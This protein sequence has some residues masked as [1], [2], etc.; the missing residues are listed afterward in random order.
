MKKA[1]KMFKKSIFYFGAFLALIVLTAGIKVGF[2][3]IIRS[4]QNGDD[5]D[6]S[7]NKPN[8]CLTKV[9]DTML[10]AD[11]ANFDLDLQLSQNE[12]NTLSI[13]S[14]IFLSMNEKSVEPVSKIKLVNTE[15]SETST[16]LK[17]SFKGTIT[18]INQ[19]IPFEINYLNGFIYAKIADFQ[20]K[21][22]TSNLSNDINTILDYTILKKF[23]IS[24]T[25]PDLSGFSLSSELL[26]GLASQLTETDTENG[27]EI[28]FNI[29]GFGWV[30]FITDS[31]YLLK[32]IKLDE[33]DFN[34]TKLS[35]DV[36]ADLTPT[37]QEI[38]EPEN[39]EEMTDLSGLTKFLGTVDKLISKGNVNG[40][41]EL[42]LLG[43]KIVADYVVD[44]KDFNNIKIYFKTPLANNM[45][46]LI[47][48]NYNIYISYDEC[49]YYFSAP[50][51]FSEIIEAVE[52]Y[53]EK[54]G[55]KIDTDEF[56]SIIDS[57][58]IKSLN[59]VLQTI[60]NLKVD[61]TGLRYNYNGLEIN[62]PIS[63]EKF[64]NITVGYKN[65]FNLNISLNDNLQIPEL[66]ENDYKNILEENLF[67]LL[68]KQLIQDKNLSL[69]AIIDVKGTKIEATLK[70]DFKQ[71]TKIQIELKVF[72]RTITINVVGK[73]IYLE[74][75]NI[76]RTKC[77]LTEILE[78]LKSNNILSLNTTN[79][80]INSIKQ[81]L[82]SIFNNSTVKLNV[83]KKNNNVEAIQI[84]NSSVNC[85]ISATDYV[86]FSYEENGTYQNLVDIGNFAKTL[87]QTLKDNKLAF[88]VALNYKEYSAI[89]VAQYINNKLQ[90]KL[91]TQIFGKNLELEYDNNLIYIN[92][93]GLKF[94]CSVNDLIEL[95]D[96]TKNNTKLNL[97]DL[98]SITNVNVNEILNKILITC[99]NKLLNISYEDILLTLNAE[100]LE[101]N[102]TAT[103]LTATIINTTPISLSEKSD[104]LNFTQLK[105]LFKATINTLKNLA[106]SGEIEAK[107][108]LFNEINTLNINYSIALQ[109]NE[110]ILKISTNFKGLNVEAIMKGK[111]IYLDIIGYKMHLNIN[112]IPDIIDWVNEKFDAKISSDI[113]DMFNEEKLNEIS[114]DIIKAITSTEN[115]AIVEFKNSMIIDI[116]YA[117]YINK[118]EF[119]SG[120][121]SLTINCV[122]FEQ[123]NLDDLNKD[124]YKSYQNLTKL[125]DSTLNLINSKKYNISATVEKYLNDTISNTYT[126]KLKIDATSLLNAY[127]NILGLGEDI[128]IHYNNKMLYFCYGGENGLKLSIQ[129]N[130]IQEILGIICSALNIDTSKIKILDDF[131]KTPNLDTGNLDAIMPKI[132]IGNPLEY[133]EYISSLNATEN[134]FEVVLKAEKLGE[135]ALNKNVVVRINY[136][137]NTIKNIVVS[138]LHLTSEKNEYINI[139]IDVKEFDEIN[140]ILEQEQYI[141]ISGA[142][143]LL[144]AF[145]NTSNLNDWHIVGKVQLDVKLRSLQISAAKLDVDIKVKLDENKKPII[146]CE[147]SSYPLIAGVNNK[148]TN[149][150]GAIGVLERHRTISVYYKDA[151]YLKT[152]DAKY[153]A[154]KELTRTTKITLNTFVNN[155]SYYTQYLLGFT[156]T[157]QTQIDEAIQKTVSYEGA[158][159]YGKIIEEFTTVENSHTI[160]INLA[161][162]AHNSDIGT[163]TLKISTLNDETTQNKDFLHRIDLDLAL[164][165]NLLCLKTDSSSTSEGLFLQDIGEQVDLTK[166]EECFKLYEDNNFNLDG[167]YEKQGTNDWTKA[168]SGTCE[169]TFMNN[170]EVVQTISGEVA[171]NITFPEMKNYFEDDSIT[172][173]EYRF[174]GWYY[175]VELTNPFTLS[176]FPRYNTTLFAKWDKINDKTYAKVTLNSNQENIST[177]T[178][179]GFVGESLTLP[180]LQN[181]VEQVDSKTTVLKTF[182]GWFTENGE[183]FSETTF[184]SSTLT[185]YAHWNIKETK[186]Y[187]ITIIHANNTI[188]ENKIEANTIFDLSLLKAYN[189]STLVYTSSDFKEETQVTNFTILG[190][191]TWYLRNKH[192]VI[193]HSS[194]T[195]N[196]NGKY[197]QEFECYENTEIDLPQFAN[198]EVNFDSYDSEFNF[199]GYKLNGELITTS[200]IKTLSYDCTYEAEWE[201]TQWCVVTFDVC[202][203][204][205]AGWVNDGKNTKMTNVSNTND[206]NQIRIQR[207][208]ELVFN[209]Y[210]AT[211]S[212]KYGLT[213][214]FKTVGWGESAD[215]VNV[216][217][218]KGATSMI[219]TSHCT[220]KPIWKAS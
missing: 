122:D 88:N 169:I 57:I 96:F 179:N 34:G 135:Y 126:G 8:T 214:D 143:D 44:F 1:M 125:I 15:S 198:F 59:D 152:N 144:R 60:S 7:I 200:K 74:I 146:A 97:D 194:Y 171:S 113:K 36:L 166:A 39:K 149:G 186:T 3:F 141:N 64:E 216:G 145:V 91:S 99:T 70:A 167:E 114:F 68:N 75:D 4:S 190:D 147:I 92:F 208:T 65:L 124:D 93:D 37:I 192:K 182:L 205:P 77:T 14:N 24:F 212:S 103:D 32:N 95:V 180:V 69:K 155:L 62:L 117:D 127:V 9:V 206:T 49:K 123:I 79:F 108:N 50:F 111:D 35:A 204:R 30:T 193:I 119:I 87:I 156:D 106:I 175:D 168:N 220:L 139:Q 56:S 71:D 160:K 112:E 181:I 89:G 76:I 18:Y 109:N 104:Y 31:E 131:I 151:L 41:I 120:D 78:F 43:Q 213:Y 94:Y 115:N 172:L 12:T 185:L 28:K 40:N 20:V 58:N 102:I 191:T 90:A 148:N 86:D 16:G 134:Y 203:S 38:V 22:Q 164:L 26:T 188:Y 128:T 121:N 100:T 202:W 45:F 129:E 197:Y 196:G 73:T 54:F 98:T 154:Y 173:K 210:V 163:L 187:T 61:E 183:E 63:N 110:L 132:E 211:A 19:E 159:D 136:E 55:I 83:I 165:D 201:E 215:N 138:N 13:R 66:K 199:K 29:M 184:S 140:A 218:Y 27:K 53:C 105:D 161:E 52:F 101:I 67:K 116:D 142:K 174:N 158:T 11:N 133:L 107:L 33:F 17:V 176:S 80:D 170:N 189:E 48:Q 177:Q 209:N 162:L 25:L 72:N 137:N 42:N 84:K 2:F 217:S 10:E 46:E 195:T 157:I 47:Y 85:E 6:P 219:I 178:I 153:G 23:G 207:N 51:D 5:L 82:S 150:V 81:I 21:I 118:V 130:A